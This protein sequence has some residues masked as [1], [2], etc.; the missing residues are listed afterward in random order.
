MLCYSSGAWALSVDQ[1]RFGAHP[2]KMRLVFDLSEHS[3][4]RVFS[5]ADPYR[6]VVDL[7]TFYWQVQDI[8]K[9]A[10]S[11]V[12]AVRHGDLKPGISRIVF[13]ME[14]PIALRTAFALPEQPGKPNRL[15]IDYSPM[16]KQAFVQAK[17][18][19]LGEASLAKI[20]NSAATSTA[21]KIEKTYKSASLG[22]MIA[23][24][25]KPQYRKKPLIV[26]DPGHGGVDPGAVGAN[27]AYEKHVTLAVAKELKKLLENTGKYDVLMTRSRDKFIKLRERV[28]FAR[29]HEADLFLSIHADSIQKKNV[30]GASFYTLSETASDKQTAALAAKENKADL[31]AGLDLS[32]EDDEVANILVDLA[33]RDTTNQG[34]FFAN[35]AVKV[36][37]S[38]GIRILENPHRHAGFAVLK[39]PDIPSMLVEVGFMSNAREARDL[40]TSSYRKKIARALKTGIDRYFLQVEK[41]H[42]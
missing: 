27:K 39:A 7:P 5:L 30:R 33:I 3:N 25:S 41:N 26:L 14:R 34:K 8:Q 19:I 2:D 17:G 38:Q 9:P 31:I 23:P 16:S 37:A 1:V 12:L 21:Q 18:Q 6:L 15:V 24:A 13:D 32:V 4:F 28:A 22:S 10:Y 20:A 29:R 40:N 35:E 42:R 36:F 11:G